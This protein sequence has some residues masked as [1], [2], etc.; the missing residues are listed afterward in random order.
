VNGLRAIVVALG[1]CSGLL[2]GAAYAQAG[3]STVLSIPR[4]RQQPVKLLAWNDFHG[5][6]S[7]RTIA[8]RPIG[9]AAVLASY[10]KRAA[11]PDTIFVHAG[12]QVG[13]SPANS[14]LL[15]DEPAISFVNALANAACKK[16][17]DPKCNVV[18]TLGNHEFDEGQHELLRL[19]HG[20]NHPNGPFLERPWQGA[21][22]PYV[23]A[24]VVRTDTQK[25]LVPPYVVK[26]VRGVPIAFI[27]A[28]L[29]STPTVV[30][31]SGVSGLTFLN[32][33]DAINRYVPELHAAGV[34]AIVV[35]IHQ[36][37]EQVRYAGPTR[38]D[39]AAPTGDLL[40]VIR[41]LHDDVDVIVSGHTHEF[42]NAL[43]P[44]AHGVSMLVTQAF[45]AST[46][47]AEIDLVLD[48]QTKDVVS[49]TARVL[50]TWAD[51]GPGKTP[52]P[53][54]AAIV[55]KANARVANQVSVVAATAG[56][57]VTRTQN[58][59]GE[60][61]LGNLIADSQRE[62]MQTDFAVIN[63]GGIRSDIDAGT[64]TWGELYSVQPF[65]N[66]LVAVTLTGQ[67]LYDLLEQQ[68]GGDQPAG[69]RILQ[70][71]GFQYTWDP[72]QP[73]GK[74]RVREVRDARGPIVRTRKYTLTANAFL[75]E[76]GDG[77]SVF[78]SATDRR[79]GPVDLDVFASYLGKLAQP[80]TAKMDG[81]IQRQ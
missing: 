35:V 79:M 36:G 8:G 31:A 72:S 25:T 16:P 46:G 4:A 6:L 50:N 3:S 58:N 30:R 68:W 63:P 12:D 32:E 52:D 59:A 27:G 57:S 60:S 65:R 71:S 18:G 7:P 21:R 55:T 78:L 15:Q 77:F 47:F 11:T 64:V 62:A 74:P 45:S 61:P 5:Q 67:Q 51:E 44:N 9:G 49:K 38:T 28:V 66:P 53:A 75:A 1:L 56:T 42:T 14:A 13:A 76:G 73:E 43:V 23:C 26:R 19:I 37:L 22:F 81:R 70:I 54:V 33:A 34:H 24:N 80:F 10:L 41:N 17:D 40:Q 29:R 20:G 2:P 48:K 69:G 39:L